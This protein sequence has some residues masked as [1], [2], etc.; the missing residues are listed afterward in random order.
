METT[1]HYVRSIIAFKKIS[2][3]YLIICLILVLDLS[4]IPL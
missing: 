4:A 3:S 1:F 2:F